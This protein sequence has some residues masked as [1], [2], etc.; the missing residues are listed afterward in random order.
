MKLLCRAVPASC[1]LTFP[2]AFG[3]QEPPERDQSPGASVDLGA[4]VVTDSGGVSIA[5]IATLDALELPELE[6]TLLH[7]TVN[8]L[9]LTHVVGAIL[10]PDSSL[11]I[12]DRVAPHLSFLSADGHLRAQVGGQGEGPGD[13][14]EIAR[15]GLAVDGSLFVYDR[16][17]R[18]FTFL[19]GDGR[20]IKVQRS[21][22]AGETGEAVPLAD[23]SAQ[24][25]VGVL[26]TRPRL[27][28]GVQRGPLFLMACGGIGESFDAFGEWA[29][30]ERYVTPT[31]WIAVGF[32]R[33]ALYD[34][35][36]TRTVVGTN[37]SLD[38]TLYE[39]T[40]V[41][42]R[43]RGGASG[44]MVTTQEREKW[45][46]LFLGMFPEGTI[47]TD[48]R[49]R[50]EESVVRDV[51]PAFGAVRVT[52]GGGLWIGD[53][54]GLSD[55]RRRWT[56][57][58]ADGRPLASIR[59]PVFRAD[60]LQIRDGS[61]TGQALVEWEV[62]IPSPSPVTELLDIADDRVA[63]LR[64]DELGREYVEVYEVKPVLRPTP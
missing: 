21:G 31:E 22:C 14:Y 44:R 32:G 53:Y 19:E 23:V 34:G 37:D 33:T 24:G 41:R 3:C 59:L 7:S 63:V 5:D 4:V 62:T 47:R 56:V 17:L 50:L 54:A 30:K 26:E 27:P 9:D 42:T 39:G 58:G 16:S 51:Y 46:N 18:R 64:K 40:I 43:I 2:P 12:A 35:R 28:A 29:G 55:E 6:L 20:V 52:A 10:L 15:I 61:I 60:W 11:V 49:R 8:E 38:L 48:W 13:H 25:F 36:G 45:T 57:L 1:L